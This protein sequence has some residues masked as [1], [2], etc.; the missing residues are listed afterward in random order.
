MTVL[1]VSSKAPSS[2]QPILLACNLQC[3]RELRYSDM[4]TRDKL[5]NLSL[6]SPSVC[7]SHLFIY[8]SISISLSLSF[9]HLLILSYDH[10]TLGNSGPYGIL[11]CISCLREFKYEHLEA[12]FQ[13]LDCILG[14]NSYVLL[15]PIVCDPSSRP[16]CSISSPTNPYL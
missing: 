6:I 4:E 8:P 16:V 9:I 3:L 2:R 12:L 5:S 15:R 7:L 11:R 10:E 14:G 13:Y 1:T